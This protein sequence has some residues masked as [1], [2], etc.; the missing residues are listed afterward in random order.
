MLEIL[1]PGC[2]GRLL[3]SKLTEDDIP[4]ER[5]SKLREFVESVDGQQGLHDPHNDFL[6]LLEDE[7]EAEDDEIEVCMLVF[8]I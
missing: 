6:D 8:I 4:Q 5:Y 1:D 2:N 3:G 7:A